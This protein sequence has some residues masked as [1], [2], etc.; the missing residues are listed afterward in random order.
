MYILNI[1]LCTIIIHDFITLNVN[2]IESHI[3]LIIAF[4]SRFKVGVNFSIPNINIEP[5]L[6]S[7]QQVLNKAAR[8]IILLPKGKP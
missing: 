2:A 1:S 8:S 3:Q 4:N 6:D 5:G 7:I